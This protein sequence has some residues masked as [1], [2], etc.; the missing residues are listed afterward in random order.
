[1]QTLFLVILIIGSLIQAA[2]IPDVEDEI[3]KEEIAAAA[4]E[5]RAL[6]DDLAEML[7]RLDGNDDQIK[8]TFE[9]DVEGNQVDGALKQL[10][11]KIRELA[12]VSATSNDLNIPEAIKERELKITLEQVEL[13]AARVEEVS[14]FHEVDTFEKMAKLLKSISENIESKFGK[15]NNQNVK[16]EKVKQLASNAIELNGIGDMIRSIEKV[17]DGLKFMNHKKIV[18]EKIRKLP[19]HRG[20]AISY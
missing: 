2:P 11:S 12:A 18:E 4:E 14:S 15:S 3:L 6:A 19:S 9:T 20:F 7:A 10:V 16:G 1:M 17:T 8:K 13:V 5:S